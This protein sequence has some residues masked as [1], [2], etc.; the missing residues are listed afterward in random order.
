MPL[1]HRRLRCRLLHS[2]PLVAVGQ[3]V[4]GELLLADVLGRRPVA[5]TPKQPQVGQVADLQHL[6]FGFQHLATTWAKSTIELQFQAKSLR[7]LKFWLTSSRHR[8]F[9]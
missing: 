3:L 7:G 2:S 1:V 9:I 5:W 6:E 8:V 4:L